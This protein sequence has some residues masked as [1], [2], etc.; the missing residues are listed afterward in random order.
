MANANADH[1]VSNRESHATRFEINRMPLP[2]MRFSNVHRNKNR[3]QREYSHAATAEP[4]LG[5]SVRRLIT[6]QLAYRRTSRSSR[7]EIYY[8]F[9]FQQQPQGLPRIACEPSR[10]IIGIMS[11]AATGSAHAICQIALTANPAKAMNER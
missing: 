10:R 2:T 1:N 3:M 5:W 7:K 8:E 11:T 9:S 6:M 4:A